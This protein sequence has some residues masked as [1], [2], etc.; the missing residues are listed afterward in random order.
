MST[1]DKSTVESRK[2][3][4][5]IQFVNIEN[6]D[7]DGHTK[8]RLD[9]ISKQ[10]LNQFAH[11]IR[12]KILELKIHLKEWQKDGD[13]HRYESHIRITY[14]GGTIAAD[15]EDWDAITALRKSLDEIDFQLKH[16]HKENMHKTPSHE[17]FI[18]V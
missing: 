10:Y 17:F 3:I 7:I 16:R 11:H 9:E 14:P 4:A 12:N 5:N 2:S 8:R 18:E 15:A 13:R 6:L 1:V